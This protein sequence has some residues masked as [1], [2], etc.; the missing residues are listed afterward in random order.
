MCPFTLHALWLITQLSFPEFPD[1]WQLDLWPP[2]RKL[3]YS[4]GN[5][6]RPKGKTDTGE[7]L[8]QPTQINGFNPDHT[9]ESPGQL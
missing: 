1:H 9:L 5:Q 7:R 3:P 6:I 4:L 2:S 8:K